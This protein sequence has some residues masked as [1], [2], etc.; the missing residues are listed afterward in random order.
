[1]TPGATEELLFFI[2]HI[3]TGKELR[4]V[5]WQVVACVFSDL[6]LPGLQP[7]ASDGAC[8]RRKFD[9]R[10]C[11]VGTRGVF[12]PFPS[13]QKRLVEDQCFMKFFHDTS[14]DLAHALLAFWSSQ[15][16]DLS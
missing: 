7:C 6:F 1:M 8:A 3:V 11:G 14:L 4:R 13:L 15:E 2:H 9:N 10:I 16:V 5:V 12:F